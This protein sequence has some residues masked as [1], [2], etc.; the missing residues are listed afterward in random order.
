MNSHKLSRVAI[1]LSICFSG[2]N[3]FAANDSIPEF[4]YFDQQIVN[5]V[6]SSKIVYIDGKPESDAL[7][8]SDTDSIRRLVSKYY[9]DQFRNSQDPDMPYFLFM[10]KGAQ[11]TLGIGGGV[12]MRM[13]YDWNGAVPSNAFAPHTIPIP[14]DPAARQRFNATPSGTYLNFTMIGHNTI[15]GDYGLYVEADFTGYQGRDFRLKKSYAMVRDF[16]LGYATSTFS[17]EAAMP[18]VID[19]AGPNNK[20]SNTSVLVRYMPCF[21]N[22]WYIAVSA[23]TPATAI[24]VTDK[25]VR[26]AS[27]WAPDGAAFVQYEW[28]KGQH[29]R[30]SGIVRSLSYYSIP[31]NQRENK[32]GWAVQ[33]SSVARPERHLTTYA[34]INYGQGYAALGGDMLYGSYDLVPNPTDPSQ[35]Y[36]PKMLGWCAGLQ[37]N[38]RPNIFS[39]IAASQTHYMPKSGTMADE[40]KTGTFVCANLFWS[41][42]PRFTVV[43]EYDWGMR[44]NISGVH[45]AASRL[46]LSAMFSF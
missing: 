36:A 15:V 30:L 31:R 33:L 42:L 34:T 18:P 43:A 39:T 45:K 37:Y 25:D 5:K 23:E 16:T 20:F 7:R 27:N 1:A 35:L 38:F 41:I 12:R 9:Y 44:R 13:F 2:V 10:S 6:N 32:T 28:K 26:S 14:A 3:V 46:N 24:D 8:A 21:K 29:V 22:K 19:A 4:H 40:Y 17:D 11:M